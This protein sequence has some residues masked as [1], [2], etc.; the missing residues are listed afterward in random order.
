MAMQ[1]GKITGIDKLI[2]RIVQGTIMLQVNQMEEGIDMLDMVTAHGVTGFDSAHGYGGGDSERVIGKWMQQ[3]GNREEVMI[4]TK[5]CHHNQDR[6]RVTP[7][8]LTS[9]LMDSLARLQSDYIDLY[10]LHRDDPD[11]PVG[12]IIDILNEHYEAGR[13]RGFGGSNWTHQRLQEANDYAEAHGLVPMTV[14]SPNYGLAEQVQN[15]WGPGCVTLAGPQEEDARA[16]YQSNQMPIFAYSSIARGFFSGRLKSD[17]PEMAKEILDGAA[18]RGYAYPVNFKRLA[19]AEEL[20]VEKGVS[21]PQI[22]IA[23]ILDSPLNVF[24]L[25]ASYTESEMI[26]NL[27]AFDVQLTPLEWA[28]LDLRSDSR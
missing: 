3:R 24:P 5:G 9:D 18:Q 7:Y 1:Y 17:Q 10:V 28:W 23:Y 16:W 13:I 19:R 27:K 25:V 6:K 26:D 22:A 11:V 14:S 21:V 20:A 4:L 15:P 2:S 8:D 12:P